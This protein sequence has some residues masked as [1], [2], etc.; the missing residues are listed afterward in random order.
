MQITKILERFDNNS[1][2]KI[3]PDTE[4]EGSTDD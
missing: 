2:G 1:V 3:I 4:M